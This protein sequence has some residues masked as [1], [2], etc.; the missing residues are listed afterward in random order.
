MEADTDGHGYNTAVGWIALTNLS[1]GTSNTV[2]GAHAMGSGTVTGDNNTSV[3][4]KSLYD[5]TDGNNN[6]AIGTDAG[7]NVA[8]GDRNQCFGYAAGDTITS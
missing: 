2:V 3:G 7:E 1:T 4:T 5:V 8:G 6:T